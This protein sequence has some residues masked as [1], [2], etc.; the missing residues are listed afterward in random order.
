MSKMIS[1]VKQAALGEY[2]D[3]G[4]QL[5]E[6]DHILELTFKNVHIAYFSSTGGTI[7]EIQSACKL[8]YHRL[9]TIDRFKQIVNQYS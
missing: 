8:F 7:E 3:L 2:A 6:D 5:T 4:F 1:E 9:N